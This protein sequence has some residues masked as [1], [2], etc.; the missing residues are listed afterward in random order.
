MGKIYGFP[1]NFPLN[2]SRFFMMETYGF[3]LRKTIRETR[4]ESRSLVKDRGFDWETRSEQETHGNIWEIYG[5]T[6]VI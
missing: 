2:Q 1:V 3:H 5:F 4:G 6:M